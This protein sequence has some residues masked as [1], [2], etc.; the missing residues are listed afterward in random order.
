M[1]VNNARIAAFA[2]LASL[3]WASGL[4]A[5]IFDPLFRVTNVKGVC[6]IK[7]PGAAAY[8][9]VINDKAYPFGTAIRTAKD[10]E[11]VI[12]L[13][14]NNAAKVYAESDVVVL[15]PEDAA[16]NR[17]LR[18]DSGK[19]QTSI[20]DGLPEKAVAIE[21][22]AAACDSLNGRSEVSFRRDK[23]G[24]RM[25]AT[26]INGGMR[27]FGPQFAVPRIKAGG[28]LAI[29]SSADRSITRLMNLS[30]DCKIELDNGTE[31]PVVTDATAKST[32]R[33]W[34]E[35]APV[36]GRLV[37]SVFAAGPD[38]RGKECF[39]YAV[40]RPTVSS[41]GMPAEP[42]SATGGVEVATAPAATNAGP[43]TVESLFK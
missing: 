7:R 38:G 8:E 19:I 5:Q 28:A 30:G 1:T 37:V 12:M 39:A 17:V 18:L 14:D 11:A 43:R 20:M 6:Q 10:A 41:S 24:M 25:E 42:V 33:I 13:S 31:T 22:A 15:L 3:L 2:V 35:H 9:A 21:T 34:R 27:V 26:V 4:R 36:G 16:T 32:V 23:D 40:G 29:F